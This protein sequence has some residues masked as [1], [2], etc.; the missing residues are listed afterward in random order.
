MALSDKDKK[1]KIKDLEK[2][3]K[4]HNKKACLEEEQMYEMMDLL[5]KLKSEIAK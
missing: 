5:E 1:K 4:D 3:L 2:K